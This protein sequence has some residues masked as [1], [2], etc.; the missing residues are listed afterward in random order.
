M[1]REAWDLVSGSLQSKSSLSQVSC[2]HMEV[3]I[4]IFILSCD[5]SKSHD[6][7][8]IWLSKWE[9]FIQSLV[10]LGLVKVDISYSELVM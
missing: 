9:P 6:R 3:E 8:Y 4:N 5:I 1:I 7:R 2:L 10:V